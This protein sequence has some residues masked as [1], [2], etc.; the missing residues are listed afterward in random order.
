VWCSE[1]LIIQKLCIPYLNPETNYV[2]SFPRSLPTRL[3]ENSS[4]GFNRKEGTDG[5]RG[6]ESIADGNRV[7]LVG[8]EVE[9]RAAIS[10]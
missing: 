3:D 5:D 2:R 9:K 6:A 8:F 1:V 10:V 7:A 4:D